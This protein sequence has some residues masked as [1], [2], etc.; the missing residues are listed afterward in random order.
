LT[1]SHAVPILRHLRQ[2]KEALQT[3]VVEIIGVLNA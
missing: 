1:Q 2:P 3:I